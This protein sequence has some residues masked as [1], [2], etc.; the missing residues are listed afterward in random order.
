MPLRE[1]T[2]NASRAGQFV[3]KLLGNSVDAR[4]VDYFIVTPEPEAEIKRAG[5][6]KVTLGKLRTATVIAPEAHRIL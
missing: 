3:Q 6:M 1:G 5:A 2:R 4:K